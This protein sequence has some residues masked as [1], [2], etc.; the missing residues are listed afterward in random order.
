MT[1]DP[2]AYQPAAAL[3]EPPSANGHDAAPTV[4]PAAVEPV[5]DPRKRS[6]LP[7]KPRFEEWVDIPGYQGYQVKLWLTYPRHLYTQLNEGD[8]ETAQLALT[9]IV[10]AHNGW[11]DDDGYELPQPADPDFWE[12]ADTYLVA[13]LVTLIRA[14]PAL[15]VAGL[16]QRSN[17]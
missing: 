13:A 4:L 10:L 17:R 6:T 8:Q 7:P 1:E 3:L 2:T 11:A 9:Q 12:K 5:P 16:L 14:Q 15:K